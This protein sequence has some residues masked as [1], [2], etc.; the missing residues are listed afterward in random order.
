[1]KKRSF[2]KKL[3]LAFTALGGV[4]AMASCQTTDHNAN[5]PVEKCN[6][7]VLTTADG[8]TKQAQVVI[9]VQ[10]PT[11]YNT[12][13]IE[14]TY[15]CYNKDDTPLYKEQVKLDI[16]IRHGAAGYFGY[17]YNAAIDDTQQGQLVGQVTRV[18][19][20]EA[21]ISDYYNLWETYMPAFIVMIVIAALSLGFFSFELF[22]PGHTKATLK[23]LFAEHLASEFTVL[24]LVLIIC[25]I[26]LIFSSW[27][28]SVILLGGFGGSL[29]LTGLLTLIRINLARD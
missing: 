24:G 3:L 8:K 17:T 9:A 7:G 25:L 10:N 27:V 22:R 19:I 20:T 28:T 21:H 13:Q 14:F 11:I 26:P 1:M 15:E 18:A 12:K 5:I 2:L 6:V 4:M 29:L 16:G 23:E